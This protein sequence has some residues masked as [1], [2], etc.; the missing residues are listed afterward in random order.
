MTA[1]RYVLKTLQ[2]I[3]MLPALAKVNILKLDGNDVICLNTPGSWTFTLWE[4][5]EENKV[6]TS[7][8]LL[9][10]DSDVLLTAVE[11]HRTNP[12][13]ALIDLAAA[14]CLYSE[15]LESEAEDKD[16]PTHCALYKENKCKYK[17][18]TFKPPKNTIQIGCSYP[19]CD[20]RCREQCVFLQF[21]GDKEREDYTVICPK[22]KDIKEHFRNK[23]TALSTDTNSMS[24]ESITLQPMWKHLRLNG[25]RNVDQKIDSSIS[26]NYVEYK[27]QFCHMAEFLS[28][29]EGKVYRP[30]T[31]H[32]AR[33][34]ESGRDDFYENVEKRI[35]PQQVETAGTYLSDIVALWLLSEGLHVGVVIRIVHSPYLK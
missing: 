26:P 1:E 6:I 27:G 21:K 34:M 33:W 4:L 2:L 31:S 29:Q 22:Q 23:V 35:R 28:L 25:N 19:S 8:E 16:S 3:G 12:F 32:L 24:D 7:N 15:Q 18:S 20:A 13:N 5:P 11:K 10:L 9:Y 14:T 30:A 17:D